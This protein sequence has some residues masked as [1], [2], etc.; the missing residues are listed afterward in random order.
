MNFSAGTACAQIVGVASS[1][2][3]GLQRINAGNAS[4]SYM[5]QKLEVT[6]GIDGQRMPFGGLYLLQATHRP[7][8]CLGRRGRRGIGGFRTPGP[9]AG[10]RCVRTALHRWRTVEANVCG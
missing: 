6:P 3:P 9:Q 1:E 7:H 8:P 5:I 4:Q 2:V 10:I